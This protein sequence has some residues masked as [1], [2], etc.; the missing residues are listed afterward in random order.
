MS[1]ELKDAAQLEAIWSTGGCDQ[2]GKQVELNDIL[3][4]TNSN[5]FF[6]QVMSNIV[7]EAA[8]PLLVG[9]SLLQRINYAGKGQT[10]TFPAMGAVEAADIAEGQ[11]YPIISPQIGGATVTATIGKVGIAV[12]MTDEMVRYSLWDLMAMLLRKA[13]QALARR[14]EVK[15]FNMVRNLG[16]PVFDNLQPSKSLFGVMT[17]R[18]LQGSANGSLTM[19]DLFDAYAHGLVQGYPSDT[20]IMHPLCWVQFVKDPV[21]RS[22][23]LANGGGTFFASWTGNPA[24]QAPWNT[25]LGVAHGQSLV[26][27]QTST[28]V[29]APH[30]LTASKLLEYP[31][32]A[33]GA[34]VLPTYFNV[35][36]RIIV[37][38][39]VP[40]DARRKLT[41][42]Y[43]CDSK[44]IGALIV[45]EEVTTEEWRDPRADI[46]NTKFRE[47]YGLA[48]LEEGKAVQV[49]KNVHVVPNEIALPAQT[50]IEVSSTQLAKIAPGT[51]LSL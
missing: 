2:E 12:A 20:L 38:P 4:S 31:Q 25:P 8:E 16:T 24:G 7:R 35:P 32:N 27:G 10:I 29:T 13:G 9:T 23:V 21:L 44:N 40:F 43:L 18:D 22:F 14:K 19:D 6:P 26:P 17:G 47:R 15:I 1:F 51:A 28:G 5:V 37:S 45:D 41:D 34:P 33:D 49:F 48:I 39:F 36:M 42:I 50:T 11:N 46:Q 30:G 3:S